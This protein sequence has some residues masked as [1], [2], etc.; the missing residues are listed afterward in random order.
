MLLSGCQIQE[1]KTPP[2][3]TSVPSGR[4]FPQGYKDGYAAELQF[5]ATAEV[6][7]YVPPPADSGNT[8]SQGWR[9]GTE[10][11]YWKDPACAEV[12]HWD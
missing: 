5:C 2:D 3:P 1:Q 4:A 12:P 11:A 8:Y 9:E 10:A 6:G 7:G